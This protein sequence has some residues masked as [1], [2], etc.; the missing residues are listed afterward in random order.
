[1]PDF[2]PEPPVRR[3]PDPTINKRMAT[4]LAMLRRRALILNARTVAGGCEAARL[5]IPWRRVVILNARTAAGGSEG[6]PS[7]SLVWHLAGI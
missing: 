1:M 7:P 6:P 2:I 5:A 4:R 3:D